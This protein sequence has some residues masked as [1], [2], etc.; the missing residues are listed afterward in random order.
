[1]LAVVSSFGLMKPGLYP[2]SN[3]LRLPLSQRHH[4]QLPHLVNDL[5][6]AGSQHSFTALFPRSSHNAL[7][8]LDLFEIQHNAQPF[9]PKVRVLLLCVYHNVARSFLRQRQVPNIDLSQHA[10]FLPLGHLARLESRNC[11]FK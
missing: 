5:W 1:M 9:S 4:R 2:S 7:P 10:Q 8:D 11:I 3:H 6:Q